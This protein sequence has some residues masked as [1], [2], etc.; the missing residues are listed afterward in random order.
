MA[1]GDS[2][3]TIDMRP[4][5][6]VWCART[7]D[8]LYEPTHPRLE[9]I[10]FC[11]LKKWTWINASDQNFESVLS[12]EW[13]EK[14]NFVLLIYFN[15]DGKQFVLQ[16]SK[17]W[18]Q[19]GLRWM[20]SGTSCSLVF[21]NSQHWLQSGV[22]L[23]VFRNFVISI[24]LFGLSIW[25][26]WGYS[27]DMFSQ[28]QLFSCSCRAV[29]QWMDLTHLAPEGGCGGLASAYLVGSWPALPSPGLKQLPHQD[30]LCA[31][32]TSYWGQIM[33]RSFTM[34]LEWEDRW[35]KG[36][37]A[38][39]Q[40]SGSGCKDP[41]CGVPTFSWMT[42][43]WSPPSQ[44]KCEWIHSF[45]VDSRMFACLFVDE[46]GLGCIRLYLGWLPRIPVYYIYALA[47]LS[48]NLEPQMSSLERLR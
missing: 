7:G 12:L 38:N 46:F 47:L 27:V 30:F 44:N 29:E 16:N 13:K 25:K 8:F 10:R 40:F 20:V 26:I 4:R 23:E 34:Q 35:N 45:T 28:M 32:P 37:G 19:L 43:P 14:W 33:L 11:A 5:V 18:L 39:A 2:A 24:T 22:C 6:R 36:C 17:H 21:Q 1:L 15:N 31:I 41:W 48:W 9:E 42:C 3:Y